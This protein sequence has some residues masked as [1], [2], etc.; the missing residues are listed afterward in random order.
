M[1]QSIKQKNDNNFDQN[2]KFYHWILN[3][4][5]L[6]PDKKKGNDISYQSRLKIILSLTLLLFST[7]PTGLK[8][9]L[10]VK[11]PTVRLNM[12]AG[13]SFYIICI[14]QYLFL[15]AHLK[16]LYKS[17]NQIRNTWTRTVDQ[18][19]LQSLINYHKVGIKHVARSAFLMNFGA[20]VFLGVLPFASKFVGD[21]H[22][23]DFACPTYTKL[24]DPRDLTTFQI[25]YVIQ[26]VAGC[27]AF[28]M[29]SGLCCLTALS[30]TNVSAQLDILMIR[31]DKIILHYRAPKTSSN[32]ELSNIYRQHS[33]ILK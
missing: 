16:S 12:F 6:W 4:L 25:V 14:V 15:V 11:N 9:M 23:R 27:V 32:K 31:I 8:I 17:I 24:F 29:P 26:F 22:T 21:E 3:P 30:L 2:C 19:E 5:G 33:E 1:V 18:K 20:I 13:L 10:E 28:N 7:I